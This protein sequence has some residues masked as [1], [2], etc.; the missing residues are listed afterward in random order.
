MLN[1]KVI[2]VSLGLGVGVAAVGG[3][4]YALTRD[5][6]EED[7][8]GSEGGTKSC[9]VTLTVRIEAEHAGLVI[10]RRGETVQQIQRK[11]NTKIYFKDEGND[12]T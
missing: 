5:E 9:P 11:T 10:G 12:E 4:I 3:V 1:R 8:T 2:W 6:L 7:G